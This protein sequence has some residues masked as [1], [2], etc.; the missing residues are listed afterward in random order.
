MD[1]NTIIG[2]ALIAAILIGFSILNRPSEDEIAK[3][4]AYNDSISL[5]Q[6]EIRE[7]EK[8]Q[9]E[10]AVLNNQKTDSTAIETQLNAF[11]DFK[12]SALGT[13]KH[14]TLENDLVEI[15]LSNKGGKVIS[16]KL[17]KYI[18]QDSLPVELFNQEE[19]DFSFTMALR[20]NHIINTSDLYFDPASEVTTDLNGNQSITFL[21]KS[22]TGAGF[23]FV[24]TL[25]SDDYMLD[26]AIKSKDMQTIMPLGSNYMIVNWDAKIRQ[27]E[28]GRQ[29]E[30]RY[31]TLNYKYVADDMEKLSESKDDKKN[32]ANKLKW[33]AFKDQ[34]FSSILIAD[35]D[36][37]NSTLASKVEAKNS[38]YMKSYSAE[39]T[40]DYNPAGKEDLNFKFYFGPNHYKTLASY[41]KGVPTEQKLKLRNIIP[42]GWG[43]F[44]WV[45]RFAIIPMFNLF[46][47]FI[48]NFGIII[49]LMTIVIKTVLF[50]LTYKS[51]VSS[52]KMRVLKP[53]IDEINARIPADKAAER[54]KAT[55]ELYNKV[56]VSP[57]SGCLPTLL[58]M[59]ILFA[60]FM[61]FPSSIEL[62]GESFLWAKDLS[63][64]D[65]I[66]SWETY[67]PFISNYYGNHVSLFTL[68]MT[69]TT[70]LSTK[71]NMANTATPD[72][73]GA[74][75][76]KWMM[77][78][79]PIMFM[80]IF[81]NYA[82]GL[83]YYYF[84]STLITVGQTYA[85]RATVDEKKLLAQLH[86]KR[87]A[88]A[89]GQKTKKK[90][91]FMERLEKM[92]REQEKMMKERAKKR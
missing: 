11:G 16:A 1:K 69:I 86:A 36:F 71:L 47:S 56:G 61:F 67:I 55:M 50:P 40:I 38:G 59:P 83:S 2:F 62:R 58:Q 27:Q 33:I 4:K 57:F 81:N 21:L 28:K 45:N 23:E 26:F 44:G 68:L 5:V 42:L 32:I 49:L 89:K 85:I 77:Y 18:S 76:M 92:Q 20:N 22:E 17:K 14:Y 10:V 8:L 82:S 52:A 19:A 74:G 72:Q 73:P 63:S 91:S 30:E 87:A 12:S 64:Y 7:A 46:S 88:N 90:S 3:Q 13:E 15:T 60:M 66:I 75:M 70:L 35:K 29:F 39:M 43:I 78:L 79:M 9:N 6:Q 48:G 54:Q 51:Y 34:Y 41:D 25:P 24:Y 37:N 80:F 65:A 84:I 31:S 53:E